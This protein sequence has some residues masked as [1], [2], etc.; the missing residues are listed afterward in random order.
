MYRMELALIMFLGE[1]SCHARF[2]RLFYLFCFGVWNSLLIMFLGE[3]SCHARFKRL[4]YF[5]IRVWNL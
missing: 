5:Y 1:N 2:I 3:N 4:L